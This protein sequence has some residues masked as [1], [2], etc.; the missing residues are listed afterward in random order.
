MYK[1]VHIYIYIYMYVC[2]YIYI[3]IYTYKLYH[4]GPHGR[5]RPPPGAVAGPGPVRLH[6]LLQVLEQ[7]IIV[8]HSRLQCVCVYIY[9]YIHVRYSISFYYS[10]L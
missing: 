3:Y 8:E 7:I 9:I 6:G 2:I 5:Q 10:I 1:C 4:V